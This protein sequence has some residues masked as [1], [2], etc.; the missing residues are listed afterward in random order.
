M[1]GPIS[2]AT[3]PH[4]VWGGVCDGWRLANQPGLSVIEERVPGGGS[5]AR[6][7][8]KLA[9]Q[10]FYVLTGEA[11]LEVEGVEHSLPTG[12]G[13]EVTPGERHRFMNKGTVEVTFLVISSP[14]TVGD[15]FEA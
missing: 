14:T 7:Y 4:Y 12:S 6:H 8:H 13:L 10:F 11:T 3:A 1:A 2:K 5:E 15:R 9:R